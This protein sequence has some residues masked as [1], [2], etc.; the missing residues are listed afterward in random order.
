[1]RVLITLM[2]AGLSLNLHAAIYKWT[3][4]VTGNVVYSDQ[5]H[6]GAVQL[7]LPQAQTYP[8]PPTPSDENQTAQQTA[9]Q[10]P[11]AKFTIVS[12]TDQDTIRNT[13]GV[14]DVTLSLEPK[15]NTQ[16]GDSIH[17][18]LDDKREYGPTQNLHFS[19]NNVDRGTH[20]LQA[21]VKNTRGEVLIESQK[22]TIFVKQASR[23]H[24]KP[25]L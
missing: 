10:P 15:L 20:T 7:D 8:A 21:M 13:A 22:V 5:P 11:Y 18:V 19:L 23:L 9:P 1:M 6:K 24:P 3:D 4:P 12:P 17:V 16:A 14:V 2:L 25:K